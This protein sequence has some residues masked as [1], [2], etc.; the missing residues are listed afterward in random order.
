MA[1]RSV[2]VAV[3]GVGFVGGQAHVPSFKKMPGAELVVI[4]ARTESRV[5]PLSEKYGVPYCLDYDAILD[6]PKVDAV[7]ISVPTPFHYEATI[8]AVEKGKHVL[9]EMPLAP[10]ISQVREMKRA[11]ERNG[12][13]L[14]PVLNFRFAPVYVKAKEMLKNGIIGEPIAVHF[15]EFIP[16]KAL[17]EQ[18][19]PGS[20]AWDIEKSGGY[21]DFT[22]SVWSIDML[23]WMLEDEIV[24]VEWV[25]NYSKLERFGGIIGYNTIGAIRF[26][27]GAVGSL[28]YGA[29]VGES[30]STS[31]LEIYGDNTNVLHTVWNN[32][33]ILYGSDPERREWDIPVSGTRVWGHYQIDSHFIDCIL[34][35]AKPLITVE[36][37]IKAQ[38]IAEKMVQRT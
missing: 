37:A 4:G 8:R 19:P 20:W 15:R 10:K 5:K 9:C 6:N 14:M 34:G 18:W 32:K 29:T 1:F 2:G 27:R 7:V 38:E 13:L 24:Y 31:R 33:I 12:V 17:A 36:D 28:H 30:A 22:L 11:A 3:V 35:K 25:S 16:A 23:R 26:S 21:P